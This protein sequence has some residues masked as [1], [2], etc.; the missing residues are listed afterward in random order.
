[1]GLAREVRVTSIHIFR[2]TAEYER[3]E[4]SAEAGAKS[5]VLATYWSIVDHDRGLLHSLTFLES[6]YQWCVH[7]TQSSNN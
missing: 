3:L 4:Y 2:V 1:M 6:D 5:E 7:T